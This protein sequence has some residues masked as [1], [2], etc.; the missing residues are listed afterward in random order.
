M[1]NMWCTHRI[2]N[3]PLKTRRQF[4]RP[5]HLISTCSNK[6]FFHS[7]IISLTRSQRMVV[8]FNCSPPSD[9]YYLQSLPKRRIYRNKSY[10][11]TWLILWLTRSESLAVWHPILTWMLGRT[12]LWLQE[13]PHS[14][15]ILTSQEGSDDLKLQEISFM[16]ERLC[17][18]YFRTCYTLKGFFDFFY[19]Y[20]AAST[21]C[22]RSEQQFFNERASWVK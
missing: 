5:S 6:A 8:E 17:L 10:C 13:V 19:N 1:R 9:L 20:A 15:R 2:G 21:H 4:L 16:N 11:E 14:C 7:F 12:V 22:S 3:F 18:Q